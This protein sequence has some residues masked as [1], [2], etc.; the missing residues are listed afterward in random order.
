M[1]VFAS[2]L[3]D[4]AYSLTLLRSS[5]GFWEALGAGRRAERERGFGIGRRERER[6]SRRRRAR[7]NRKRE[8]E[9]KACSLFPLLSRL[10]RS[11]SSFP[12]SSSELE[13]E[14]PCVAGRKRELESAGR[15]RNCERE[16]ESRK[17]FAGAKREIFD[18]STSHTS[19]SLKKKLTHSTSLP[20]FFTAP[21]P[22]RGS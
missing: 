18:F 12:C 13:D 17:Q 21:P 19:T 11:S 7:R 10:P 16:W 1:L 4:K 14:T 20:L 2:S 9:R 8:R 5:A 15:F 6:A 22:S 3:Y